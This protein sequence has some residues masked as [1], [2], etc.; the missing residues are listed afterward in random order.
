MDPSQVQR[1]VEASGEFSETPME[2]VLAF[3]KCRFGYNHTY[4]ELLAHQQGL[5]IAWDK[6]LLSLEIETDST[7]VIHLLE[8]DY[9]H[10]S[11]YCS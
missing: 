7:K 10:L 3:A 6:Q 8:Q 5:L 1:R 9:P 4:I 2:T 11:K